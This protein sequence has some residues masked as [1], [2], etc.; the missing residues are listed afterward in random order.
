MFKTQFNSLYVSVKDFILEENKAPTFADPESQIKYYRGIVDEYNTIIFNLENIQKEIDNTHSLFDEI[1]ETITELNVTFDKYKEKSAI[2]RAYLNELAS[3]SAKT[4]F[5]E[6][7]YRYEQ[8]FLSDPMIKIDVDEIQNI[9]TYAKQYTKDSPTFYYYSNN[10]FEIDTELNIIIPTRY[11]FDT[12]EKL[13]TSVYNYTYALYNHHISENRVELENMVSLE[14]NIEEKLFEFKNELSN[15][16]KNKIYPSF[17]TTKEE[18]FSMVNGVAESFKEYYTAIV[19]MGVYRFTSLAS[20]FESIYDSFEVLM[21][22]YKNHELYIGYEKD[23]L[24]NQKLEKLTEYVS[25]LEEGKIK[26]DTEYV[27]TDISLK[28]L[29]DE[30]IDQ[31]RVVKRKIIYTQKYHESGYP[32]TLEFEFYQTELFLESI[33]SY[34]YQLMSENIYRYSNIGINDFGDP[35]IDDVRNEFQLLLNN[36]N[37]YIEKDV[38]YLNDFEYTT[39]QQSIITLQDKLRSVGVIFYDSAIKTSHSTYIGVIEKHYASFLKKLDDDLKEINNVRNLELVLTVDKNK[40]EAKD[41][42]IF[43]SEHIK[44]IEQVLKISNQ[45]VFFGFSEYIDIEI[46]QPF[47]TFFDSIQNHF[48]KEDYVTVITEY[49]DFYTDNM[50]DFNILYAFEKFSDS[51]EN[52]FS[53]IDIIDQLYVEEYTNDTTSDSYFETINIM[54][55]L[56]VDDTYKVARNEIFAELDILYAFVISTKS[57]E[58]TFLINEKHL[59]KLYFDNQFMKVN[60]IR[61]YHKI[62]EIFDRYNI[63]DKDKLVESEIYHNNKTFIEQFSY[64]EKISTMILTQNKTLSIIS[65]MINEYGSNTNVNTVNLSSD[66]IGNIETFNYDIKADFERYLDVVKKLEKTEFVIGIDIKKRELESEH[67]VQ[68]I[69]IIEDNNVKEPEKVSYNEMETFKGSVPYTVE[70]KA[71]L[72]TELDVDGNEI[73]ATYKWFIGNSVKVGKEVIHTFY[74]EGLHSIRCDIEYPNGDSISRYLEFELTG[75]QN[76][77]LIKIGTQSYTPLSINPDQPKLTYKDPETGGMVTV[78]VSV[79]GNLVEM[80]ENESFSLTGTGD[81]LLDVKTGLVILG[82]EG[83]E[84]AG[85]DYDT[86]QIFDE[87][88]TY[89]EENEFLFDF[90][91]SVPYDGMSTVNITKSRFTTFMA[92]VPSE[93]TNVYEIEKASLL[94]SIGTDVKISIGDKLVFMNNSERYSVVEIVNIDSDVDVDLGKYDYTIEFRYFVNTSLNQYDRDE[95]KPDETTMV[96]PTLIFKTDVRELFNSLIVRLE[97]INVLREKLESSVDTESFETIS[98]EIAE[99]ESKN[100]EFYLFEELDKIK[101]KKYSLEQLYDGIESE[102]NI[103]YDKPF[104][105]LDILIE[106]YHTHINNTKIFSKYINDINAYE[107]RK[108]IIDL[109]I[110]IK[111]YDDQQII[112][113]TLIDTYE[114]KK[115]DTQYYI[116]K[117]NEIKMFDLHGFIDN[118][119]EYGDMLVNLVRKLRDLLFKI[120]LIINFPIMSDGK[121]VVMSDIYYRLSNDMNTDEWT[122]TPESDLFMLNKKLELKYGYEIEKAESGK[123]YKDFIS[124]HVEFEKE[125]FG[126][127]LSVNDIKD[128]SNYIQVVESK[129]VSEYDDFFLIPFWLDYLEK[130]V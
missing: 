9:L 15:A 57:S 47:K 13:L 44:K 67:S 19:D 21:D 103:D 38:N 129:T 39:Y 99:L 113:E 127:C 36:Y 52:I 130:N 101:A 97:E 112:L 35:T 66:I 68:W 60:Y 85:N 59:K 73:E 109:G 40:S 86:S 81:D 90:K 32:K 117:I 48:N 72:E 46:Y 118:T 8:M 50:V 49:N 71:K 88:F 6:K 82:F 11:T 126:K 17:D 125:L 2:V 80:I 120:K 104:D 16:K 76:E 27:I 29:V 30:L 69:D 58:K 28:D 31:S 53:K 123:P 115:N 37:L 91:V 77:Q 41:K 45:Y 33:K 1:V 65:R 124:D 63:L 110:L 3:L 18:Y 25:L 98:S 42:I 7:L 74:D 111:L 89:P 75:P 93:I 54:D 84:F 122:E 26:L 100:N 64:K 102:L 79:D 87:E 14:Q 107:F 96:V 128:I 114:Y 23:V 95:F 10:P 70:L 34:Y 56:F 106:K 108:N 83:T 61:W 92:K 94:N 116:D 119:L 5:S 105:E 43:I 12:A 22:E 55:D 4:T 24:Y 20:T 51:V 78:V 62:I 121:H